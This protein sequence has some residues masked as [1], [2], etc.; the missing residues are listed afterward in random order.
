MP[1]KRLAMRRIHR[2]VG[3]RFGAGLGPRAIARELGISH[4]TVCEYLARRSTVIHVR[5][6]QA[7]MLAG[8]LLLQSLDW[9]QFWQVLDSLPIRVSC[10]MA[11]T[12]ICVPIQSGAG[13][14]VSRKAQYS[15]GTIAELFRD[16]RRQSETERQG[17]S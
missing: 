11:S 16:R 10:S 12:T 15:A 14:T 1:T 7:M 4:S 17:S 8:R 9:A 5:A 6:E 13:S 2:L 3:L